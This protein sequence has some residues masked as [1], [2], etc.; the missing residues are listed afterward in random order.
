M[1]PP[2][3]SLYQ[4]PKEGLDFLHANCAEE[5]PFCACIER[6][7]Q[8]RIPYED[9]RGVMLTGEIRA[10]SRR[11]RRILDAMNEIVNECQ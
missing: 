10:D 5:E 4:Y 6:G 7:Y 2:P 8:L 11:G 9:F 1:T 3:P